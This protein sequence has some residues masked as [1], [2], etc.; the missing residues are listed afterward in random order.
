[1]KTSIALAAL[2]A[3]SIGFATVLP[4]SAQDTA[5]PIAVKALRHDGGGMRPD[6]A[7]PGDMGRGGPRFL[8]LICSDKG[9]EALDVAFTRMTHRIDL[10]DAQKT[11]F[12]TFKTTAL[13]TQT[14]FADACKAAM[15]DQTA[16]TK[17]D[18]LTGLKAGL[19]V[20][21]ARLTAMNAVLPSF[22]AFFTSLTD[23]QKADLMPK[24]D[25]NDDRGGPDRG[26]PDRGGQGDRMGRPPAP[27]RG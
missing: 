4:A 25:M 7:G 14:S 2:V 17:P 1:M 16:E 24:R 11:L 19:K 8:A 20:D 10:T 26:G 5:G 12:D 13:T 22:E 27:G 23:A 18:L 3:T 21:Q 9:A 15:P 6:G